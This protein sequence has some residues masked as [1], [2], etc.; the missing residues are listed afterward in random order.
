MSGLNG[1]IE[2]TGSIAYGKKRAEGEIPTAVAYA[3]FRH[4]IT[5]GKQFQYPI[6]HLSAQKFVAH[7]VPLIR[8]QATP[9]NN[10]HLEQNITTY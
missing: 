6:Q 2:W 7:A 8:P 3:S 1:Q 9:Q 5:M 10:L 4:N